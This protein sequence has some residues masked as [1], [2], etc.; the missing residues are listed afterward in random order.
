MHMENVSTKGGYLILK[1]ESKERNR[2]N[3]ESSTLLQL[4]GRRLSDVPLSSH[5]PISTI[6][7]FWA[8]KI[9]CNGHFN[10]YLFF[11]QI[12]SPLCYKKSPLIQ[13]GI[14]IHCVDFSWPVRDAADC[15]GMNTDES[16]ENFLKFFCSVLFSLQSFPPK[17]KINF[18][19]NGKIEIRKI[20]FSVLNLKGTSHRQSTVVWIN[21]SPLKSTWIGMDWP[22]GKA[23]ESSSSRRGARIV[24]SIICSVRRN[25]KRKYLTIMNSIGMA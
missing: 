6:H 13:K 8:Q 20:R 24:S 14:Y 10:L 4:Y 7:S 25:G 19:F 1:S 16:W 18:F 17:L 12:S 3:E 23:L 2:R 21:D 15:M 22:L 9:I 11:V 5:S